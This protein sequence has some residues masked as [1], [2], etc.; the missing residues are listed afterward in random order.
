MKV[1]AEI[2]PRRTWDNKNPLL[3]T[4]QLYTP[5]SKLL[6]THV[7]RLLPSVPLILGTPPVTRLAHGP[8]QPP[9]LPPTRPLAARRD[10][11]EVP[12]APGRQE[13]TGPLRALPP[14]LRRLLAFD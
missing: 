11:H 4:N 10:R 14:L 8:L 5:P 9:P 6:V 7:T 3:Y 12:S 2:G 1:H 13:E